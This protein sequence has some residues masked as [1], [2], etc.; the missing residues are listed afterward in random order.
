VAKPS[1]VFKSSDAENG[2]AV[3]IKLN[4]RPIKG[5]L[6]TKP[7]DFIPISAAKND[8]MTSA[9]KVTPITIPREIF[10]DP[11]WFITIVASA[12]FAIKKIIELITAADAAVPANLR[13]LI[14]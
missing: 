6:D 10:L 3:E 13:T 4:T 8:A 12:D 7:C 14:F 2:T 5:A 11:P 9:K 1:E